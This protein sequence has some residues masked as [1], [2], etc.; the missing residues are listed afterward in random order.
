[1][2]KIGI[3]NSFLLLRIF[4][5]LINSLLLAD[6]FKNDIYGSDERQAGEIVRRK[7]QSHRA[8]GEI[9]RPLERR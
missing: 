3:G 5:W 8:L 1:M 2:D 4:S 9:P 6:M 7:G